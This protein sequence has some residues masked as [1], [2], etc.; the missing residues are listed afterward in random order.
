MHSSGARLRLPQFGS[1]AGIAVFGTAQT[2]VTVDMFEYRFQLSQ[3]TVP[4]GQ[5]T[6][7]I[8]NRG[9]EVHNFAIAG[10][11]S[12][13]LLPPG[14]TETWTIGLPANSYV[15][16]CDVPFHVDRGMTTQLIVTP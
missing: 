15:I 8:T 11:K 13:A 10:S 12:G 9:T 6:F 16:V 7:V 5:V 3:S 1:G 14:G 4:S 2:T